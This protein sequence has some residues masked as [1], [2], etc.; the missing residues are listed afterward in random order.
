MPTSANPNRI[1]NLARGLIPFYLSHE[2]GPFLGAQPFDNDYHNCEAYIWDVFLG[3]LVFH[4]LDSPWTE[5][6]DDP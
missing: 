6:N 2:L 1:A 3:R 5:P 4:S